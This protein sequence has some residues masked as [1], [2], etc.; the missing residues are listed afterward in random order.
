MKILRQNSK[1]LRHSIN[2]LTRKGFKKRFLILSNSAGNITLCRGQ[3]DRHWTVI[4]GSMQ[5]MAA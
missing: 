4:Y 3:K 2:A 1:L 5:E